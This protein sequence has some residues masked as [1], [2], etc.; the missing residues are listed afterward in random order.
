LIRITSELA[1]LSLDSF[2]LDG[3]FAEDLKVDIAKYSFITFH[4]RLWHH[5]IEEITVM[6]GTTMG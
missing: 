5:I 3:S 2:P 1:L 6:S 4:E